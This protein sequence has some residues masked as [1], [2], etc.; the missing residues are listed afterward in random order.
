MRHLVGT[1]IWDIMWLDKWSFVRQCNIG[2]GLEND[3]PSIEISIWI[4]HPCL[5]K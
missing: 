4:L 3:H 2:L 5:M 1:E